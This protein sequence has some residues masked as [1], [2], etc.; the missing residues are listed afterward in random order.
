MQTITQSFYDNSVYKWRDTRSVINVA[1]MD[2]TAKTNSSDS[3][4]ES[5]L[6]KE[7]S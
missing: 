7:A 1:V 3:V 6:Y 5:R 2:L 4:N